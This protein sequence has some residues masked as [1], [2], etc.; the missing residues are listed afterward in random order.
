MVRLVHTSSGL[1]KGN[2]DKDNGHAPRHHIGM[3]AVLAFKNFD[4]ILSLSFILSDPSSWRYSY[5]DAETWQHHHREQ[6]ERLQS[7]SCA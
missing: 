6:K 4:K 7:S 3:Y 2:G 1:S 5:S